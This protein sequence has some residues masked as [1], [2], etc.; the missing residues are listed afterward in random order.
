M[1]YPQSH[2]PQLSPELF[3]HPTSEYRATP[4]WAWNGALE[5]D[6]LL[7][8]VSF[9]KKM[10]LGGFHMHVRSGLSTPYLS[11][12]FMH[13]IRSCTEQAK[14]EQ[15]RAWLYDEDRWASGA[16]GGLVTKDPAFRQ[17]YIVATQDRKSGV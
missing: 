1:L 15:M 7:R 16:A 12:D 6:E 14:K 2:T 11:D 13:L 8:Q 5:E 3:A 4:F 9:F 17:R 10:G